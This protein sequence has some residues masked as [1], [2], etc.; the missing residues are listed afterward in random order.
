MTHSKGFV[1]VGARLP[2]MVIVWHVVGTHAETAPLVGSDLALCPWHELSDELADQLTN[3]RV[4]DNLGLGE[5][6][7]ESYGSPEILAA[8]PGTLPWALSFSVLFP[9]GKAQT[10]AGGPAPLESCSPVCLPCNWTRSWLYCLRE[11]S[12]KARPAAA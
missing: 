11:L 5:E 12:Q 10:V 3:G 1:R 6:A 9:A 4:W 2:S 7:A 8:V